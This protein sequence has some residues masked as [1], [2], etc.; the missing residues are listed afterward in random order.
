MPL[1]LSNYQLVLQ[2]NFRNFCENVYAHGWSFTTPWLWGDNYWVMK[3]DRSGKPIIYCLPS[4]GIQ[5]VATKHSNGDWWSGML[6]SVSVDNGSTSIIKPA[7]QWGYYQAVMIFPDVVGV[8]PGFWLNSIGVRPGHVGVEIDV[9]EYYGRNNNYLQT[10]VHLWQPD[11]S[12]KSQSYADVLPNGLPPGAL[13]TDY[14]AFGVDVEPDN[15]TF[16]LDGQQYWQIQTPQELMWPFG[17]M[18]GFA[19]GGGWPV[20]TDPGPLHMGVR[21]ISY[22]APRPQK[23]PGT[24]DDKGLQNSASPRSQ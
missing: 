12:D 17:F 20:P 7:P 1:D 5:L 13:T 18:V 19:M 2:E 14:H 10:T 4:N 21:S 16:Y 3:P 8:W 15:V 22:Y 6:S 9:V 11:H 23:R 24:D